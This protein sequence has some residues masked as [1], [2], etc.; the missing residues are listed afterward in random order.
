MPPRYP[1]PRVGQ[2]AA[3]YARAVP[4]FDTIAGLAVSIDGYEIERASLDVSTGFTRVTTTVVMKGKGLQ[5]RGEDVTYTGP[6]HDGFPEHLE[7]AATTP[8]AP[9]RPRSTATTCSRRR[10]RWRPRGTIAGGHSRA[11]CSTWPCSSTAA[12]WR[13][14]SAGRRG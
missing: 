11:R 1:G 2:A 13:P 5:G 6:D 8:C 4:L 7:V 12:P 9:L 3:W 14:R 10:P